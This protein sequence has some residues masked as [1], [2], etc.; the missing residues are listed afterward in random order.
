M[1][2]PISVGLATGLT[3]ALTL[4]GS[5]LAK[6]PA[7]A[8]AAPAAR[9]ADRFGTQ[10]SYRAAP[11]GHGYSAQARHVADCLATYRRYDPGT[12]RVL[13]RPGVTRRCGL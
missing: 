3:A 7:T 1:R 5:G 11:R 9:A 6:P 4:A 12:D 8:F 10:A 13:V 2:I